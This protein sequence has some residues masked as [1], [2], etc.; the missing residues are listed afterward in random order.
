MTAPIEILRKL[1]AEGEL[2]ELLEKA[3]ETLREYSE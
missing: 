2:E 1:F 3:F